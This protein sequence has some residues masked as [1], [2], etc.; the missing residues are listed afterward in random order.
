MKM[1]VLSYLFKKEN[2]PPT[3]YMCSLRAKAFNATYTRPLACKQKRKK[4]FSLKKR[5]LSKLE[6]GKTRLHF[7]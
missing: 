1:R 3:T 7:W 2:E 5:L 6:N 4:R